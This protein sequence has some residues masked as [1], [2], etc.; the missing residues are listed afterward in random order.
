MRPRR[1]PDAPQPG[2]RRRVPRELLRPQPRREQRQR[3]R[4][5]C[6]QQL[7][8]A[9][10]RAAAAAVERL[11]GEHQLPVRVRGRVGSST[12]SAS[13]ARGPTSPSPA[14]RRPPRDQVPGGLD[15]AV[16]PGPAVRQQ[17]EPGSRTR[18][19]AAGASPASAASRRPCRT[20]AT[21]NLVGMTMDDLQ[22][23]YKFYRKDEPHDQHR[24][25]L[26]AARGHHPQHAARVQHEQ[27]DAR[28][29]T[30]RASARRRAGTSRRP[31]RPTAS[32][33]RPGDCAP[34]SVLLLSPWFKRVDFGVAKRVETGGS[35]NVEVRFDLLNLFDSPNFNP[36]ANPGSGATIFRTTGAYHGPEQHL[37]S[38]RPHRPADDPLQLV[39]SY[40]LPAASCQLGFNPAGGAG[41]APAG[42]QLVAGSW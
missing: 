3:D 7:Q 29:A 28:R 40:Q 4:Q 21:C 32:R 17:H 11:L 6:V 14:T 31:T 36:V 39:V 41:R 34:R 35:T 12:A 24:R 33:S 9:A 8:R 1:Q 15:A 27:H 18:W 25:S 38:G 13:A 22:E 10:A 26:D 30:R 42:W 16:R 5:R 20:S 19:R 2:P 37:R 23:L